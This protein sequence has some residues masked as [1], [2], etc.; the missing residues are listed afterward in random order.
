MTRPTLK[1]IGLLAG[2]FLL[3]GVTGA[4]VMHAVDNRELAVMLDAPPGEAQQQLRLRALARKLRLN[5]EQR[6]RIAEILRAEREHCAPPR[7]R[8]DEQLRECRERTRAAV[9]EVLTPRQRQKLDE[10]IERRARGAT[11]G[12]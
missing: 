12:R 6:Q 4:A 5:D 1:T 2:M 10:I 8:V 9:D 3:G 7:E 11:P